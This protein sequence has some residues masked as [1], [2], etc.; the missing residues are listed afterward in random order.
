MTE[1]NNIRKPLQDKICQFLDEMAFE[2]HTRRVTCLEE[3]WTNKEL[4]Q[5]MVMHMFKQLIPPE[6][7]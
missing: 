3:I 4:A 1:S 2:S 5:A 7:D 6:N